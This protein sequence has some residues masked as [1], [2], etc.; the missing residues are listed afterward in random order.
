[1]KKKTISSIIILGIVFIIVGAIGAGISHARVE[2]AQQ[3]A[4]ISK[5]EAVKSADTLNLTVSN[6]AHIH[7]E[8]SHDNNIYMNKEV[9]NPNGKNK[10]DWKVTQK[11]KQLDVSIV[12]DENKRSRSFLFFHNV[13][14]AQDTIY[15]QIPS[16]LKNI[17]VNG[18]Q[19]DLSMYGTNASNLDINLEKGQISLG[20][21][22]AK[23]ININSKDSYIT[24]SELKVENKLQ[25]QATTGSIELRDSA[26]KEIELK[27]TH[28]SIMTDNTKGNLALL[29]ENG[30]VS[31][32]HQTG[33]LSAK[34]DNSDITFHNDQLQPLTELNST[35]GNILIETTQKSLDNS[36]LE[37][38]TELGSL[39]IFNKNLENEQ[40]LKTNKGKSVLKATTNSGDITINEMDDYDTEYGYN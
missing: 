11:N 17:Q 37:L 4:K 9:N 14:Y 15:L 13:Y 26:A 8:E 34:T 2:K 20:D 22:K 6:V 18:N 31:I 10:T 39:D 35:H 40:T 29:S 38:K 33:S 30:D 5:K 25:T 27:T 19:V 1:M 24:L 21:V 7:I 3:E 12:N 32:N 36:Q 16:S 28:G 23:T